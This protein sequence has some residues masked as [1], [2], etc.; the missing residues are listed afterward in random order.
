MRFVYEPEGAEPKSWEFNP[1]KLMNVEAEAIEKH[2]GMTFGEWTEKVRNGS[3]LAVHGL[4]Y[5]MLKRSTPTLRWDDVQFCL[6]DV[7]FQI[8][9]ADAEQ[10]IVN[11][12]RELAAGS[13]SEEDGELLDSLRAQ[14]DAKSPPT[15]DDVEDEGD[16]KALSSVE[17][18]SA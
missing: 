4:L 11:L 3:I 10:A 2:T 8:D 12:E 7:D 9:D 18:I 17:P 5:V 15:V 14:R 1:N 16:P 13:L 6:D